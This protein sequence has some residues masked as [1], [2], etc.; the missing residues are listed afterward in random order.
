[1]TAADQSVRSGVVKVLV[2]AVRF[3][4]LNQPWLDSYLLGL[5]KHSLSPCVG[6]FNPGP[7]RF[8]SWLDE[9]DMAERTFLIE[10]ERG[11]VLAR[12]LK[13]MMVHPN[14]ALR[15]LRLALANNAA[16]E[17]GR[18][19]SFKRA[20]RKLTALSHILEQ[21]K[22]R[23]VHSHSEQL[24]A[25]F[26]EA[27]QVLGIPLVVTFHGLPPAGV[28][29]I[30]RAERRAIARYASR[31][32]VNTRFALK[33][34]AD[35]GYERGRFEVIPQGL[36]LEEFPAA[37]TRSRNP[38]TGASVLTVGRFHR[39]KG[40]AYAL[41]ALARLL[42]EGWLLKWMFVGVGPDLARLERLAGKL[43][44]RSH[45]RFL[46]GIPADHLKQLYRESDLF[47]LPS[48]QSRSGSEHVETQGVVLQEAQASGC[49]PIATRVGG[50]PECI[51]DGRD[52]LLVRDRSHRAIVDAVVYLL[53]HPER[54]EDYRRA[55]RDTVEHRFSLDLV[56]RRVSGVL[57]SLLRDSEMVR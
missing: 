18:R 44:V 32:F 25:R 56:S 6:T 37:A 35:V 42:R 3:P 29:S 53:T 1:M 15:V 51:E 20:A 47:V 26:L 46:E 40:Q 28:S 52:G 49:I 27:T 22:V 38:D 9:L 55:A 45:V 39:D 17:K 43:G 7:W 4:A 21:G 10:V 8:S 23:I 13:L 12:A 31:I 5:A 19:F 24:S 54:W 41:L 11:K 48:V 33:H 14:L 16:E 2:L 30:S 36:P 57:E 50:I 34:A